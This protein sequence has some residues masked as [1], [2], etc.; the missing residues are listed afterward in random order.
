MTKADVLKL[1]PDVDINES[2]GVDNFRE[3]EPII[4]RDPIAVIIQHPTENLYLI[5]KWSNDWCG[6][7]TGGIEDGDSVEDTV[8]KEI[9]EETGFKHV[10]QIQQMDCVSHGLF[11]HIV[12]HVN[13]LAH[14]HLVFAKLNDLEQEEISEEELAIAKFIWVE[15]DKVEETLSRGDMKKLWR[16]YLQ[17]ELS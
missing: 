9:L 1:F 2:G 11:Y 3:G 16:F 17:S 15:R 7:L 13:R 12:K 5:A 14:Y 4:E 10:A 6:F 8:R